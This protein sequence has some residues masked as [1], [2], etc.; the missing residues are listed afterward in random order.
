M[1]RYGRAFQ[2]DALMLGCILAGLRG[3]DEFEEQ[4]NWRW[5][6]FGGFVLATGLA[7][8]ITT[9]WVLIPFVLIVRRWPIAWRLAASAAMLVPA[10]AWYVYRLATA[11]AT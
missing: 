8:K 9:S 5:A 3:W 4:G 11:C 2:P 6:V 1:I 7:L 10:L